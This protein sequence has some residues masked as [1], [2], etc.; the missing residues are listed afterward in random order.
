MDLTMIDGIWQWLTTDPAGQRTALGIVLLASLAG[1][2][3]FQRA[4]K[5][6]SKHSRHLPALAA[7]TA[8]LFYAAVLSLELG[9]AQW[10]VAAVGAVVVFL[11]LALLAGRRKTSKRAAA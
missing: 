11:A 9:P 3:F 8:A 4:L 2:M 6:A 1:Y 5:W 10:T 7:V